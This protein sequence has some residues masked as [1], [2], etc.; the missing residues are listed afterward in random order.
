MSSFPVSVMG[1]SGSPGREGG[2]YPLSKRSAAEGELP[3]LGS[4]RMEW[5][6]PMLQPSNPSSHFWGET[7]SGPLGS[8]SLTLLIEAELGDPRPGLKSQDPLQ[9][10]EGSL[11]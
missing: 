8:A 2:W 10:L 5:A 9:S 1:V 4:A 7:D 11:T 3:S 6:G